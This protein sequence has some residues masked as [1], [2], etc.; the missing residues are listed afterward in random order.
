MKGRFCFRLG[1]TSCILADE[2]LPNV[3]FLSDKVDDIELVLVESKDLSQIPSAS[4]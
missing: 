3:R 1:T 4:F 2:I